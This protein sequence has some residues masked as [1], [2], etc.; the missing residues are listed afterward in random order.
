MRTSFLYFSLLVQLFFALPALCEKYHVH[1]QDP[2]NCIISTG[3][4]KAWDPVRTAPF[5]HKGCP[6]DTVCRPNPPMLPC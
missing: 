3:K 2:N 1:S 5:G 6:A 4:E